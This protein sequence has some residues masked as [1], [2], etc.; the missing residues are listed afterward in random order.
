MTK[1]LELTVGGLPVVSE[2][3]FLEVVTTYPLVSGTNNPETR[4]RIEKENPQIAE[5]VRIGISV[6]PNLA[7][8]V[9]FEMGCQITYE[10]L[11]A[12]GIFNKE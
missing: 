5:V 8:G 2:E 10:L 9:Y 1:D 3:T 12:Q 6:A 7:A 4:M 11:R